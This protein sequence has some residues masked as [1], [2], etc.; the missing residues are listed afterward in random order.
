LKQGLM[1]QATSDVSK[2]SVVWVVFVEALLQ[3]EAGFI[4]AG[5]CVAAAKSWKRYFH[6]GS[7]S[8]RER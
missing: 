2:M 3:V 8:S 5:F 6:E 1:R 7:A 4:L